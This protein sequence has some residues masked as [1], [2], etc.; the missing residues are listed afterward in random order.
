MGVLRATRERPLGELSEVAFRRALV[1]FLVAEHPGPEPSDP[2]ERLAFQRTWAATLF[3][4]GWAAPSWPRQWG[5][6]EL[7]LAKLVPYHEEMAIA[8]V[9][10]LPSPNAYIVGP[11]ILAFGTDEQRR[12]FLP[13]IVRGEQLWCQ[14]FSE[15][16]A[17][18]DL[19]SLRTSARRTR[20][21][22]VVSGQKVW[23]SK[24]L[25][26]DW[27]FTLVRTGPAEDRHRAITY[28]LIDLRSAGVTVR[29]LRDMTGGT[30]FGE[31]FF[32][33]V[34]VPAGQRLGEENDGW[35]I[36]R[37]SLGHE[38]S[39]SR[40]ALVVKYRRVVSELIE[41]AQSRGLCDD[42]RVR[43]QLAAAVI[44]SRLLAIAFERVMANLLSGGEPGPASSISR[45][46]LA[47]FEQQ[48]HETAMRV[49][50]ADALL[51]ADDPQAPESGRWTWGFLNT[52]ASTIGAGT[53]EMQRNT[54]AERVLGLPRGLNPA[55]RPR[56][57]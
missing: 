9:P 31:V 6:M 38:R 42:P 37:H 47:T 49:I 18:S 54:I 46:F 12:R 24:A 8:Q 57:L 45:L 11:S 51:A 7:P 41:L 13:G 3:E 5:G 34:V 50:G 36:G 20:D 27:I 25:T 29:P 55:A 26:S 16:G 44:G 10:A 52:R 28:L 15:P 1:D 30:Y 2:V 48:L 35:R 4:H 14:G 43:Q 22:Y 39:T 23:T 19:A 33:D 21:A 17:G 56:G 40:I 32:D 53:S